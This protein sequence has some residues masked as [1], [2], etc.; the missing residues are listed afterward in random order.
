MEE[1]NDRL[2]AVILTIAIAVAY[3][4]QDETVE[5]NF[6]EFRSS[7]HMIPAAL[8]KDGTAFA[9]HTRVWPLIRMIFI[10][11][12]GLRGRGREL[13]MFFIAISLLSRATRVF[14]PS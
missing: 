1:S 14:H 6:H 11:M 2:L 5:Y 10:L 13:A 7:Y 9:R 3:S 12:A 8:S 4:G